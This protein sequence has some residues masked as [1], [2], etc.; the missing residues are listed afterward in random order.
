M[1]SLRHNALACDDVVTPVPL[2]QL[3][4]PVRLEFTDCVGCGK[5]IATTA[6]VCRHCDTRRTIAT[7]KTPTLVD[8]SESDTESHAALNLGGYGRDDFDDA[9]E[10]ERNKKNLWW[11][12][13]WVLL[14]FFSISALYPWIF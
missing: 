2:S 13:A 6:P 12:V 7:T 1:Y 4:M 10:S 11:Y 14:I 3:P 8:D 5:R 9:T